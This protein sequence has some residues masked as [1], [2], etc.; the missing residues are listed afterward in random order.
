MILLDTQRARAVVA[1]V[2]LAIISCQ[3]ALAADRASAE[4][5]VGQSMPTL[6]ESARRHV[7]ALLVGL[8]DGESLALTY[9]GEYGEFYVDD[10]TVRLGSP[11]DRPEYVGRSPL[12]G[13]NSA[14]VFSLGIPIDI[15]RA[16]GE[17]DREN[18]EVLPIGDGALMY[19]AVP[20]RNRVY[21]TADGLVAVFSTEP[22]DSLRITDGLAADAT[23]L[24]AR[25]MRVSP[26]LE[27][28]PEDP[29]YRAGQYFGDPAYTYREAWFLLRTEGM[30]IGLPEARWTVDMPSATDAVVHVPDVEAKEARLRVWVAGAGSMPSIKFD[31]E[32]FIEGVEGDV[33]G[34]RGPAKRVAAADVT[35]KFREGERRIEPEE[36]RY[37]APCAVSVETIL[38]EGS[39]RELVMEAGRE[40]AFE[41]SH[42]MGEILTMW[43]QLEEIL[44]T[45]EPASTP[46]TEEPIAPTVAGGAIQVPLSYWARP[47]GP[48]GA[49]PV[50]WTLDPETGRWYV[51]PRLEGSDAGPSAMA[52]LA[53]AEGTAR[54]VLALDYELGDD[55]WPLESLLSIKLLPFVDQ[56]GPVLHLP[57]DDE[58]DGSISVTAPG[59]GSVTLSGGPGQVSVTLR[60]APNQAGSYR[61][62]FAGVPPGAYRLRYGDRVE[63]VAVTGEKPQVRV[64]LGLP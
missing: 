16:H 34:G 8:G 9:G 11:L 51:L 35:E 20:S 3:G 25:L 2:A 46:E 4:A 29:S 57:G 50:A 10:K 27:A 31:G 53:V 60:L 24:L 6:E 44:G 52:S 54:L 23:W 58:G 40:I 1:L 19:D 37:A 7:V 18:V 38:P 32:K 45:A 64:R 48:A 55:G 49:P 42:P 5:A 62:T 30:A 39:G 36:T 14:L 26:R 56:G 41:A 47:S 13:H 33:G 17:L 28:M 22:I 21:L 12:P 61:G 43:P 63:S 15:D 59:P